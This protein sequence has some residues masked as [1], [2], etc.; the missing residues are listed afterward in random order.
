MRHLE[1]GGL[2]ARCVV[3][4]R[5]AVKHLRR[6]PSVGVVPVAI[7]TLALYL[8]SRSLLLLERTRVLPT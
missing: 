6:P 7:V 4:L 5:D 2:S 8:R 1:A 3:C